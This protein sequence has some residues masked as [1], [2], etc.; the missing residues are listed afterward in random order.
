MLH[1]TAARDLF[2]SGV[3]RLQGSVH[4][5][6]QQFSAPQPVAAVTMK[7]TSTTLRSAFVH[8]TY[9]AQEQSLR[10]PVSSAQNDCSGKAELLVTALDGVSLHIAEFLTA[11]DLCLMQRVGRSW[12]EF[13]KANRDHLYSALVANQFKVA[14]P[15]PS[16]AFRTYLSLFNAELQAEF[17]HCQ[18]IAGIHSALEHYC[19]EAEPSDHGFVAMFCD[20]VQFDDPMIAR[21]V[22]WKRQS[23]LNM[24]LAATPDHVHAFRKRSKYVGPIAF[25]P[26]DN[27]NWPQ[28]EPPV[29]N[30]PGCLG[31]AFDRVKMVPGYES[32]KDTVAKSI[33]KELLIF[34]TQE[35]AAAY[36]LSIGREPYAAI[37]DTEPQEAR[38]RNAMR[39]SSP[40]RQKLQEFPVQ[41]RIVLLQECIQAVNFTISRC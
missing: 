39:F 5:Q 17:L 6:L 23:A 25:V 30:A 11:Q 14:A 15:Q 19:T 28:F 2:A 9:Q 35:N 38:Y 21:F 16:T 22:A 32:L 3:S 4:H 24:V 8:T 29:V 1:V 10:V 7:S 33:L 12:N 36:G 18:S 26:V 34:D 20:I 37:L 27:P 13:V 40:L 41:K 31:Y